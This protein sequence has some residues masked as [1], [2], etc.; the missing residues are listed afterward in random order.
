MKLYYNGSLLERLLKEDIYSAYLSEVDFEG[1]LGE[2][3]NMYYDH[4]R[5]PDFE[6]NYNTKGQCNSF[7]INNIDIYLDRD[8]PDAD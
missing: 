6:V 7:T 2:A 3:S 4:D 8:E 5:Y 1:V